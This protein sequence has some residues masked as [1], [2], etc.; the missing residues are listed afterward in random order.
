MTRTAP[1]HPSNPHYGK[2][3]YRRRIRLTHKE[4]QVYGEL[5][6]DC[7]GFQVSLQHDG[8]RVTAISGNTLRIPMNTCAGAFRPLQ[9]LVGMPLGTPAPEIVARV[10][11][12]SNCTHLYD[13]S[14]LAMAHTAY[15]EQQRVYDVE[16]ADQTP[17]GSPA[18][19]EVFLNGASI[20]R[21]LL[22]WTSIA[23]PE[24]LAGRPVLNGFSAWANEAFRGLEREA[25]FVLCKG[26]FVAMSRLYDMSDIGGQSAMDHSPM[27]GVCYSY[28]EG[29]VEHA[30][31][32]HNC[33]RDFS[34][35]PEQL[36]TFQ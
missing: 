25:A 10:N 23:E 7:H 5:E 12:R 1:E 35:T 20:H 11:P 16:V 36:L 30:V 27:L 31:R 21:W 2:G 29:V 8:T 13:L 17:D 14:L 15:S 18:R 4:H 9:E 6:D 24:A 3:L 34:E 32:N 26:V 28:S 19:A 33:V 22:N